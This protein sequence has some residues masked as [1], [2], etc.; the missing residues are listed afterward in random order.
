MKIL[1]VPILIALNAVSV[2]WGQGAKPS[3]LVDL[4]AYTGADREQILA[5]GAK[6]E[7]KVFWYTSLTGGPN[8]EIPK[9]F[10]ARYPGIKVE[11]YRGSSKDIM[12]KI[13]AETQAKRYLVDTIESTVPIL[14]VMRDLKLLAAFNSPQLAA[15][16]APTKEKA[17]KG[18]FHWASARETYIGL[19]YNKNSIRPP[20]VPKSYEDLL[21]PELRGKLGFATSDTGSR[22]I[23]AMLKFKGESFLQRLKQQEISLYA[24]SGRA[25]LDLV[26]SGEVGASPTIFRSQ[27]MT[28]IG[29]GAPI[30]WLPMEI[31]PTN[32]GGVAAAA[33][34]P[35]PHAALLL[36]DFILGP[37]GQK[38]LEKFGLESP[39]KDFGFNR[40]YPE[41]GMT[42]EQYEESAEKW[43]K[44][45]G[46]V[47][48]K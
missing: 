44:L 22:V 24:V 10:E 28:S 13:L 6:G 15:Y 1:V 20:A 37:E 29:K 30:G 38:I 18:L 19:G 14:R 45:L 32:A 9:A 11:T 8:Q 39:S 40:W 48:R 4:A 2:A 36:L 43:D 12:A 42:T 34:A 23:G 27:A 21:R 3:S 41:E 16:P 33:R 35:H 46:Q 25:L 5:A 17:D 26:I 7:G 31:V 47:G